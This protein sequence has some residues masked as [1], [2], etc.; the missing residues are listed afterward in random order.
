MLFLLVV[1]WEE[2][3]WDT[4][5][6]DLVGPYSVTTQQYQLGGS[7]KE[8]TLQPTFMTMLDPVTGW[9]EIVEVHNYIVEEIV[10]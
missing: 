3:P 10:K 5:H 2:L 4:I 6:T 1:R 9:I 8:V 7:Q